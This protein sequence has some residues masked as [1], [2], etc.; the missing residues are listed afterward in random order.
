MENVVN[1]DFAA[2]PRAGTLSLSNFFPCLHA[3]FKT[4]IQ[5]HE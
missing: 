5:D 1:A 4:G 2:R 3:R